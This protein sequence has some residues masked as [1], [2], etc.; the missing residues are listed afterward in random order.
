MSSDTHL[1]LSV[2][3]ELEWEPSVTAAQIGVA[4]SAGVVTLTGQVESFAQKHA[5]SAA[6][7]RV[8][9]VLAV[10]DELE[11]QV[12]F[13][14][15][16]GDDEIAAATLDRLAW[17]VSVPRDAVKVVVED[18]WVT[19]TGE[20]SWNYQRKAAE[21]DVRRLHGVTGLSN[22]LTLKPRVNAANIGNDICIALHRSYLPDP[23][24]ITVT[25]KGGKVRLTGNVH[26]WHARQVAGETAWG[27][28][29]TME[30][31][32]LIAVI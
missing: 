19:L 25:A 16:R 7:F 24:A 11:V 15:K 13:E 2:L 31:E 5:A 20:V 18:G 28:P 30:V 10:A 4:A 23:D 21:Q 27:S 3:A 1:Q 29:G 32:N 6:A 8:K 9:G 22:Q 12:P 26:S 14:R 17:D